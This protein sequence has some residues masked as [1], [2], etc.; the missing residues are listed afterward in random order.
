MNA[1]E[2]GADHAKAYADTT[3]VA[4]VEQFE[5]GLIRMRDA[6]GI[7]AYGLETFRAFADAPDH[8]LTQ[9]T[10]AKALGCKPK[11][12]N[13]CIGFLAHTL[14]DAMHFAPRS[15]YRDGFPRWWPLIAYGSEGDE[16][17]QWTLRPELLQAL[18][19]MKWVRSA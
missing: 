3:P 1:R 4:T 16:H 5:D 9:A 7:P 6:Y 2:D 11:R 15:H 14:A 19:N 12:A 8:S 17:W 18:I 10:L 13:G